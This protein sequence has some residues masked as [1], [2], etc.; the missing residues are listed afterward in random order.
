MPIMTTG[1]AA[2][3]RCCAMGSIRFTDCGYHTIVF[4]ALYHVRDRIRVVH[5]RHEQ[6]A[7]YMALGAALATGKP[8]VYCVVPGPGF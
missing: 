2:V 7:G 1:E 5:T 8:Q 6:T 4:D 3:R